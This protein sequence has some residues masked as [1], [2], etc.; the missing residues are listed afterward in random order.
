MAGGGQV[1]LAQGGP[2]D[3]Q[4]VDRVGLA[5][6]THG[7]AGAWPS[8][9]AAELD[10]T[11]V[12]DLAIRGM[13]RRGARSWPGRIDD[14]QLRVVRT[15]QSATTASRCW[16]GF[17]AGDVEQRRAVARDPGADPRAV[18]RDDR[19]HQSSAAPAVMLIVPLTVHASSE[20]A[21]AARLPTSA[22]VAARP[23]SVCSTRNRRT[24]S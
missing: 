20:A 14:A 24:C 16:A 8:A 10:A 2:G 15:E 21:N 23:V 17:P 5:Q 19:G 3:R 9:A 11:C 18:R 4:G 7:L 1:G 13:L 22:S 12:G 6:G